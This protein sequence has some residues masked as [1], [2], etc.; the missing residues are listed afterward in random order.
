MFSYCPLPRIR[1]TPGII[2][3]ENAFQRDGFGNRAASGEDAKAHKD[4][5]RH[6]GSYI[7]LQPVDYEDGDTCAYKVGESIESES[8]I[9]RKICDMSRKALPFYRL[10]PDGGHRSALYEEEDDLQDFSKRNKV[11]ELLVPL[12]CARWLA[13]TKAMTIHRNLERIIPT[14][15]ITLSTHKHTEI[16]TRPMPIIF[17]IWA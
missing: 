15:S 17:T 8:N 2:F 4:A 1:D 9:A 10:V 11:E 6:F 12:T 13:P 7:H 5:Q 3:R 16:L 14:L